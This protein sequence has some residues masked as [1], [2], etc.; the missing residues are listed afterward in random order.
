M[1]EL[2]INSVQII[3]IFLIFNLSY[4]IVP[5]ILISMPIISPVVVIATMLMLMLIM[6]SPIII[7]TII[8]IVI[9]DIDQ[10]GVLLRYSH[11]VGLTSL[12]LMLNFVMQIKC[13]Q[14]LVSFTTA[15]DLAL[16]SIIA[17]VIPSILVV[18]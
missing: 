7:I 13:T 12:T 3:I 11:L 17:I 15:M 14:R 18:V 4:H 16:I 6:A 5:M 2:Q 1:Y 9:L 8:V 10:Y